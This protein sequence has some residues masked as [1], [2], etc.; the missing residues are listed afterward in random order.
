VC[1]QLPVRLVT[2]TDESGNDT[3]TLREW[4]R[5]D[6]GEGGAD[7]HWWCTDSH[8]A[9]VG[10]TRVIDAMADEIRELIGDDRFD[11]LQAEM[12]RPREA[13]WLPHPR[14]RGR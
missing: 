9:F 1:W 2:T 7:F 11:W 6:W 10:S 4:R 14:R 12:D 8:E 13:V 5:A 3:F